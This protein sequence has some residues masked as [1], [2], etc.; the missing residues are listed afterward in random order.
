MHL[1]SAILL[2]CDLFT[3]RGMVKAQIMTTHKVI[4][5]NT[6]Y[7]CPAHIWGYHQRPPFA[8]LCLHLWMPTCYLSLQ[9]RGP[10]MK[11]RRMVLQKKKKKNHIRYQAYKWGSKVHV[12]IIAYQV[13]KTIWCENRVVQQTY[14]GWLRQLRWRWKCFESLRLRH[15]NPLPPI[16]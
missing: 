3:G 9:R 6:F 16:S 1:W 8:H 14:V 7:F 15:S 13:K 10:K 4:L 11:G 5:I 2:D 12:A